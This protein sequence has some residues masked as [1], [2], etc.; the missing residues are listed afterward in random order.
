MNIDYS[1]SAGKAGVT[2]KGMT[3]QDR[4]AAYVKYHTMQNPANFKT[5]I[6]DLA[7]K[8]VPLSP[9][10]EKSLS[11]TAALGAFRYYSQEAVDRGIGNP[12]TTQGRYAIARYA[13][14][15]TDD[16]LGRVMTKET[17]E[18][19]QDPAIVAGMTARLTEE[20]RLRGQTGEL[21]QELRRQTGE[22]EVTTAVGRQT[23]LG[24]LK[25]RLPLSQVEGGEQIAQK[26][27]VPLST[28]LDQIAAHA[29]LP[30]DEGLNKRATSAMSLVQVFNYLQELYNKTGPA[31][32]ALMG[33]IQ[34]FA[35]QFIPRGLKRDVTTYEEGRVAMAEVMGLILGIAGQRNTDE[36]VKR[37]LSFIPANRQD[38]EGAQER[39]NFARQQVLR[40]YF[41][42][43][44]YRLESRY[45]G[46]EEYEKWKGGSQG[47]PTS[48]GRPA[49]PLPPRKGQ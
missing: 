11:D 18:S 14:E 33:E 32:T 8:G 4:A 28:S 1:I 27:N 24:E 3:V 22:Q 37:Y 40:P 48:K 16:T 35:R 34:S 20:E 45:P 36:D 21:G 31:S 5:A 42:E 23:R 10:Q 6:Q 17:R 47:S 12:Q 43:L 38:K 39:F 49:I 9:E 19:L 29:R 30:Y 2:L 7:S 44:D 13:L 46:Q 25:E 15:H 41:Q 26:Y